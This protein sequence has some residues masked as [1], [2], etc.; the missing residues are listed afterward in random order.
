[1]LGDQQRSGYLWGFGSHFE[2]ESIPDSLPIG[3]NSPR[4]CP[5]GLYAEQLSGTAFTV[6]RVYNQRSW[7]YRVLPS[8]SHRPFEPYEKKVGLGRRVSM[9]TPN[10]L[11]WDPF[12]IETGLD[13]LDSL[14]VVASAGAPEVRHGVAVY[15]YGFAQ[16]MTRRAFYNSDGDFLIGII[17]SICSTL[18]SA[19]SGNTGGE[20]RIWCVTGVPFGDLCRSK[21]HSIL[22]FP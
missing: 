15:V 7:L 8:V 6:P 10:Q 19:S 16:D 4:E 2:S 14:K 3:Q 1:M 17:V 9:A 12:P 20:D 11:R 22:G 5:L 18:C 21:R 13:F